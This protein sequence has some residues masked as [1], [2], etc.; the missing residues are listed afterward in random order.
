MVVKKM[1]VIILLVLVALILKCGT[2]LDPDSEVACDGSKRISLI[3]I[4]L[5]ERRK[6]EG[7]S[8]QITAILPL[9]GIAIGC[10]SDGK[11]TGL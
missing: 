11:K 10:S 8:S 9:L 3:A 2:G 1:K 4:N 5:D 7:N 6:E